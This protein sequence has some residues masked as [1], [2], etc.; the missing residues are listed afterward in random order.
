MVK[1][2]VFYIPSSGK[3]PSKKSLK[4]WDSY[5]SSSSDVTASSKN[6]TEF[7]SNQRLMSRIISWILDKLPMDLLPTLFSINLRDLVKIAIKNA[8]L[9]QFEAGNDVFWSILQITFVGHHLPDVLRIHG[10]N[11]PPQTTAPMKAP[12]IKMFIFR[13][14]DFCPSI[15]W[16]AWI[17]M[18]RA[19]P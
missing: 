16:I 19:T 2:Y 3:S 4:P 5:P 11:P 17:P 6:H 9:I 7:I 18:G 10:R 8:L 14:E 15:F 13:G 12:Q 1:R